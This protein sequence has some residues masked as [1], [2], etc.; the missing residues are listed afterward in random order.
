MASFTLNARVTCVQPVQGMVASDICVEVLSYPWQH[1]RGC[2]DN[3][4]CESQIPDVF[5]LMCLLV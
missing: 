5:D 1:G 4:E 3:T 2:R